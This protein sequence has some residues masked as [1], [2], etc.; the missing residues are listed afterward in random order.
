[1]QGGQAFQPNCSFRRHHRQ[2]NR[3]IASKCLEYEA[4][5]PCPNQVTNAVE[6]LASVEVRIRL[7]ARKLKAEFRHGLSLQSLRPKF[8]GERLLF[9]GRHRHRQM[10]FVGLR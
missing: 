4:D 3:S 1:M 9:V 8:P 10:A 6:L 5:I 7:P 2:G